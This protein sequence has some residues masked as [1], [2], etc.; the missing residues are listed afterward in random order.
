M[1]ILLWKGTQQNPYNFKSWSSWIVMK[2]GKKKITWEVYNKNNES[3]DIWSNNCHSN[4]K[5]QLPRSSIA[6]ILL[7][8]LTNYLSCD[9]IWQRNLSSSYGLLEI[10]SHHFV[11][12]YIPTNLKRYNTK[13]SDQDNL[14]KPTL[15]WCRVLAKAILGKRMKPEC[16]IEQHKHQ[17]FQLYTSSPCDQVATLQGHAKLKESNWSW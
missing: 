17:P 3:N 9:I 11:R 1:L 6:L 7:V 10:N 5:Y 14:E 12:Y 4:K 2:V 16:P 8:A 13:S 15:N